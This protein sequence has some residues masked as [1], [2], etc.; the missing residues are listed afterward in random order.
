[1]ANFPIPLLSDRK[2]MDASIIPRHA[3]MANFPIPLISKRKPFTG[4]VVPRHG[5]MADAILP[6]VIKHAES[7]SAEGAGGFSFSK[8]IGI[9]TLKRR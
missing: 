2:P 4:S 3:R 6:L 1:M 8:L 7:K 5:R 9:P